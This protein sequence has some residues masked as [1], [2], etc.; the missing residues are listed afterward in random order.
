[1]L[2]TFFYL[3]LLRQFNLW[4]RTLPRYLTG[5]DERRW[6]VNLFSI[7]APPPQHAYLPLSCTKLMLRTAVAVSAIANQKKR[8]VWSD[9]QS[10]HNR[11]IWCYYA[12]RTKRTKSGLPWL[13]R[14][15]NN[16]LMYGVRLIICSFVTG[17]E[18][19]T[20]GPKWNV[21]GTGKPVLLARRLHP[22]I[23]LRLIRCLVPIYADKRD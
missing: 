5:D 3:T 2:V 18:F 8:N 13:E 23:M 16:A 22:S 19:R 21:D 15:M 4:N 11:K 20:F 1:M 9:V 6:A 14:K 10:A 17:I 7:E 12:N